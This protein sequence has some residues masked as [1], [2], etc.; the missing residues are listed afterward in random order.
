MCGLKLKRVKHA[1]KGFHAKH[2]TQAHYK[3]EEF[4]RKLASIQTLPDINSDDR[5]QQDERDY[6]E[7]LKFWSKV[8]ESILKQKSRVTWL[9]QGIQAQNS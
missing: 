6:A 1:L 2:F 8:D 7:K 9:T 5:I 3:M 4:R